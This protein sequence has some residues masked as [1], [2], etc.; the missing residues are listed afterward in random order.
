[1]KEGNAGYG[2]GDFPG[3]RTIGLTA[4]R[5]AGNGL[6]F[7]N[8]GKIW[9]FMVKGNKNKMAGSRPVKRMEDAAFRACD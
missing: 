1:L 4:G 5:L 8:G 6:I 3:F 9:E 7:D 2:D